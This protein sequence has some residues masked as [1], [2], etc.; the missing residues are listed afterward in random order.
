MYKFA[1]ANANQFW[2]NQD[3]SEMPPYNFAVPTD[4]GMSSDF[5][6]PGNQLSRRLQ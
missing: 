6:T 3:D 4:F 1:N 5:G 2:I